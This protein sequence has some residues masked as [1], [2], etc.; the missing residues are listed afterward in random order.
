MIGIDPA[1]VKSGQIVLFAS[2]NT[3]KTKTSIETAMMM[4]NRIA[5]LWKVSNH[6]VGTNTPY[7]STIVEADKLVFD[8]GIHVTTIQKETNASRNR[9]R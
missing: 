9:N 7:W 1:G 3:G 4:P 6:G 8:L 5:E 2:K